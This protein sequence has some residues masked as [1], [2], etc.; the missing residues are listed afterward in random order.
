ME[1]L[2]HSALNESSSWKD[3]LTNASPMYLLARGSALAASHAGALLFHETAKAPAV[4]LSSGQFRHGPVE[5][6]SPSFHAIV[7]GTPEPTKKL[8]WSLARDL[9]TMGANVRWVGAQDSSGSLAAL[10]DCPPGVPALLQPLFDVIPLQVAAYRLAW[11]RGIKLGNFRY[12]SETTSDETGFPLFA[13]GAIA[14]NR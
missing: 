7:L 4:V 1:D 3:F 6:A 13:N 10:T 8:D 12:A 14:T 5:A 11:W 2:I 9:Q